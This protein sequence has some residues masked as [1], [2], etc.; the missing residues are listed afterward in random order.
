M[1]QVPP[2][3]DQRPGRLSLAIYIRG[4]IPLGNVLGSFLHWWPEISFIIGSQIGV[5]E[6]Y[7]QPKP[8]ESVK[9]WGRTWTDRVYSDLER[10]QTSRHHPGHVFL[11]HQLHMVGNVPAALD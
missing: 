11:Y 2:I 4:D 6:T 7:H 10:H 5:E 3:S 8:I 1:R 9:K